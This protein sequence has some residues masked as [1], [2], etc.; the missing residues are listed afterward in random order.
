MKS[1]RVVLRVEMVLTKLKAAIMLAC[2]FVPF[3]SKDLAS[4]SEA[5]R[6]F[7]PVQYSSNN[8]VSS[9]Y[10]VAGSTSVATLSI[11]NMPSVTV[12]GA[13][14]VQNVPGIQAVAANFGSAELLISNGISSASSGKSAI[15]IRTMA[16]SAAQP[17]VFFD[18][19]ASYQLYLKNF[20][21]WRS[22]SCAQYETSIMV[23]T[24]GVPATPGY[25]TNT[26]T[27]TASDRMQLCCK[28]TTVQ[29]PI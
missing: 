22:Y 2:A 13:A 6:V 11:G 16:G 25:W 9:N 24:D 5:L 23:T 1:G 14:T 19:N 10:F 3:L 21:V 12:S 26:S 27:E 20:C 28:M 18:D 15:R 29:P 17:M 4:E 8:N 7:Y